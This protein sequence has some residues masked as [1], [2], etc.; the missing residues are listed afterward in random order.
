MRHF[1][2]ARAHFGENRDLYG[3]E[4]PEATEAQKE[5]YN[6][7]TAMLSLTDGLAMLDR[8]MKRLESQVRQLINRASR[9]TG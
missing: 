6:F 8:R 4:G 9:P 1:D 5:A 3:G 7:Y 2:D